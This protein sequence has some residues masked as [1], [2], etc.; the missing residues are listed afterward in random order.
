MQLRSSQI[1]VETHLHRA[2]VCFRSFLL[3]TGVIDVIDPHVDIFVDGRDFV[4]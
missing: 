3:L 4:W 2:K 1:R